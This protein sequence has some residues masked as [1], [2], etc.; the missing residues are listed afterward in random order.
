MYVLAAR[1]PRCGRPPADLIPGPEL[2]RYSQDSPKRIVRSVAC[3]TPGC[4]ARYLIRA[5][6]YQEATPHL[7]AAGDVAG[8]TGARLC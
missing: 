8:T 2:A 5:R 4:G 1:C 3:T 7:E 6:D